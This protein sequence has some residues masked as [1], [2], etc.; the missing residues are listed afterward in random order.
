MPVSIRH[1]IGQR[2]GLKIGF[3]EESS[4]K[5]TPEFQEFFKISWKIL[6]NQDFFKLYN[7]DSR[8]L[9]QNTGKSH[10]NPGN[11]NFQEIL[12]FKIQVFIFIPG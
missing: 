8:K 1:L 7:S 9:T 5:S 12:N 10:I 11:F 6:E 4:Q 2:I 3:S